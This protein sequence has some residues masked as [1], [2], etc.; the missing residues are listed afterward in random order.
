MD[1]Q[2]LGAAD[3]VSKPLETDPASTYSI[4]FDLIFGG[5]DDRGLQSNLVGKVKAAFVTAET[6]K[7]EGDSFTIEF[8]SFIDCV[9][10]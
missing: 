5:C 6:E 10:I 9:L 3:A 1:L 2:E 7:H 8:R 4:I